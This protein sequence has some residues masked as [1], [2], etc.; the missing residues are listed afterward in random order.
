MTSEQ[1]AATGYSTGCQGTETCICPRP[2]IC[3]DDIPSMIFLTISRCC[4]FFDYPLY[5]LLFLSKTHN[6]NNFLQTTILGIFINFSDY[7]KVHGLFGII[8]G[9]ESTTHSFFHILRWARRN[10]DIQYLLNSQTGVT[11]L[12]TLICMPLIVLPMSIPYLKKKMTF[13]WRKGLHYL[14]IIWVLSLMNHAPQRI[15]WLLGVPFFMYAADKLVGI[16]MRTYLLEN[17]VSY[18]CL[19]GLLVWSYDVH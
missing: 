5:M 16:F 18:I 2:T 17:A 1:V 10:D 14:S 8:V 7:H 15:F 12:V 11:G 4:A 9:I 13:E 3:A 19:V 6:L